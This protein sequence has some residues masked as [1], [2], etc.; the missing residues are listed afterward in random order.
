M[1]QTSAPDL[2]GAGPKTP[3]R[4]PPVNLLASLRYP[5]VWISL[6]IDLIPVVMVFAYGWTALPLVMLY[7]LENIVIGLFTI[8]RM[9]VSSFTLGWGGLISLFLVPFFVVHY[10]M[11]CAGHGTFLFVLASIQK[12][13]GGAGAADIGRFEPMDVPGM[14]EIALNVHPMMM[15]VLGIGIAWRLILFVWQFLLRGDYAK[16]NPIAEMFS[17]YGRIVVMHLAIFAG[18]GALLWLGQPL[19]GVL[20]LILA[21]AVFGLFG[22]AEDADKERTH[23]RLQAGFEALRDGKLLGGMPQAQFD[24]ALADADRSDPSGK[25]RELLERLRGRPGSGA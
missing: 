6:F 24:A 8:A 12:E 9:I 18:F 7:W 10:G 20:G 16:T 19:W 2:S 22:A 1:T 14:S 25:R 21:R 5:S 23:A 13:P 15:W 3:P 11:F 4:L 17:P